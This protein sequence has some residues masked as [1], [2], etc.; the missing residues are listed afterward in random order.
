MAVINETSAAIGRPIG[1]LR[2]HERV[3]DVLLALLITSLSVTFHLLDLDTDER[4]RSA[5]WWTTLLIIASVFP[6]AWRRTAPIRS[7]L[8]VVGA[9]ILAALLDIDGTGFLGVVIALYAIGAHSAGPHRTNALWTISVALA[10]LFITGVAVGELDVGSFV[11]STVILVTAFV[12]GDNLRRRRE[13]ADSLI[14]RAERAEREHALIAQQQ[15]S[16]ERTRIARELHDVVAHSVSVMVIQ[17][18]A[19]RR[20]LAASPDVATV[21][22]DNIEAT[23]RQAMNELR[24]ILG[25][26]RSNSGGSADDVDGRAPQPSMAEVA[27]LIE[28]AGDL[29]L[30][31]SITGDLDDL[32]ASVTL[33]GYRTLQEA[34]T[35]V[36][37][38][39]GPVT[40]VRLTIEHADG[41]LSI[42]VTDDGRGAAADDLGPGYGI[43]GMHE[44]A[45]AVAGS[46][47]AGPQ[48]GGGWQVHI[49]LPTAPG[50][51]TSAEWLS[52]SGAV[53]VGQ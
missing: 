12:L 10:L 41:H 49:A 17:A 3:A 6:V 44:R 40:D 7:G 34:L 46:V 15:I 19:A 4:F 52:R 42:V 25:V 51:P 47:T 39:A 23:G 48:P 27:T 2:T 33:T 5:T 50:P 35:N 31:H 18:A 8:F 21:A 32:S 20:N 1:W 24:G 30:T 9:Q 14:E 43:A 53:Q 29:P 26:L 45:M 11:S 38:H 36:R 16:A 13:K 22:L 37:R 28:S